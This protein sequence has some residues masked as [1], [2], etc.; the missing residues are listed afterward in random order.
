VVMLVGVGT[1]VM[2]GIGPLVLA[3]R[4][5]PPALRPVFRRMAPA[6]FGALVATGVFARGRALTLDARAG[7][8]AAA[9]GAVA[10]KARPLSVVLVAS[11]VAA[12]I[13]LIARRARQ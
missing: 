7:G 9:L 5:V 4:P 13:R 12:S 11:G 6:L 1:M 3:G 8:L 10:L 2:K